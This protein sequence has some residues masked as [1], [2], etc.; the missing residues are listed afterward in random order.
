MND[1]LWSDIDTEWRSKK[2]IP[3]T[4][5]SGA[6]EPKLRVLWN[7]C[8]QEKSYARL[9][10]LQ[11]FV[12]FLKLDEYEYIENKMGRTDKDRQ[13]RSRIILSTIHKVKGLEFDHVIITPSGAAF[14]DAEYAAEEAKLYYVAMTRAK[15]HLTYFIGPREKAWINQASYAGSEKKISY[16]S[17]ARSMILTSVGQHER[18]IMGNKC[19]H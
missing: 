6:C 14:Q 10:D 12:Q 3:E 15:S 4:K 18:K 9:S 19:K 2:K 13:S 1:E 7:A 16:I 5:N 8:L 11:D 17:K